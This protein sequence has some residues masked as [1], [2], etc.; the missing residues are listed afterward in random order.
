MAYYY[1]SKTHGMGDLPSYHERNY[2]DLTE[3]FPQLSG[4]KIT[5]RWSGII[6]STTRFCMT[7]GLAY[8]GRVAWSIPIGEGMVSPLASAPLPPPPSSVDWDKS[9][10]LS[11]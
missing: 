6:A 7:P 3:T 10:L 1:G 11:H 9:V 4:V 5:H 2:R 8:D